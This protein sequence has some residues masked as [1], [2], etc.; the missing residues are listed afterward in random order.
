MPT[1]KRAKLDGQVF[2]NLTVVRRA[3]RAEA[4]R[5]HNV[6]PMWIVRCSCGVERQ[7]AAHKLTAGNVKACNVDGHSWRSYEVSG[8]AHKAPPAEYVNWRC[9][10]QR[11]LNPKHQAFPYYGGR[12]ITIC[13][14]WSTSFEAF[15]A[16]MGSKPSPS[17]TIDRVDES[18]NYEPGNCRWATK[19]E[20][21]SNRRCC[22]AMDPSHI[23]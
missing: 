10:K 19:T 8:R 23:M 22:K 7:V 18:G 6:R 3:S 12:G 9:M 17:H 14:A 21:S 16:D 11:C 5:G 2:G 1:G 15:L 20:Q 13:E 4:P